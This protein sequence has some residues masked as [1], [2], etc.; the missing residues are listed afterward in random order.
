MSCY[1][2]AQAWLL[3]VPPHQV[4]TKV[5]GRKR[6]RT[7]E[8][9]TDDYDQFL[10]IKVAKVQQKEALSYP[11]C[12]DCSG[13]DL[14]LWIFNPLTPEQFEEGVM[15]KSVLHIAGACQQS[16]NQLISTKAIKN[17]LQTRGLQYTFEVDVV[18]YMCLD[19]CS[20]P[21]KTTHN[22]NAEDGA[23]D[24]PG[25]IADP[26]IIWKRYNSEGFSLRILHPQ[27]F[28]DPLWQMLSGLESYMEC[29]MGCNA[30]LTPPKSQGFAPHWDDIDAVIVQVEGRKQWKLYAPREESHCL[31]RRSSRDMGQTEVG[32]CIF[33]DTLH[34]GDVLYLPRGI[35]HQAC[36]LED[37]H[38]LHLTFS[39]NQRRTWVDLLERVLPELS[40]AVA[41]K[42]ITLRRTLP[43][44]M[45]RCMGTSESGGMLE[46]AFHAS[47][48]KA[49]REIFAKVGEC[50]ERLVSAAQ[51]KDILMTAVDA[52]V[53][54]EAIEFLASRMPPPSNHKGKMDAGKLKLRDPSRLRVVADSQGH[55]VLYH[56]MNNARD[57]H[58]ESST[59]SEVHGGVLELNGIDELG[60]V[61]C[62]QRRG[63]VSLKL[64]ESLRKKNPELVRVLSAVCDA[65]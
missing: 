62:L 12:N 8:N 58:A 60:V 39:L 43:Q 11:L 40:T 30:Y 42:D 15:E 50:M 34:P 6:R 44:D 26:S 51:D 9:G 27:R 56:C 7:A 5:P 13:E 2:S 38:S 59:A 36:T 33:D 25:T 3:I 19:G 4:G 53:D 49:R 64:L 47:I 41:S 22:C 31:P 57:L 52:A 28:I 24:E 1:V 14:M 48:V 55:V 32:P 61:Q 65:L 20:E 46:G 18:K 29:N 21:V 17:L 35:V 45:F 10:N 63:K 37:S 54:A 23:I 16:F